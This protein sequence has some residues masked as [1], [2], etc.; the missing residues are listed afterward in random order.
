MIGRGTNILITLAL[1]PCSEAFPRF[2]NF[3][4]KPLY[5]V[6]YDR[7]LSKAT[8]KRQEFNFSRLS[9]L[10]FRQPRPEEKFDYI[11]VGG[12]A[13][14]CPLARTLSEAGWK[15]LLIERGPTRDK[16]HLSWDFYGQGTQF[17]QVF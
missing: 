7:K 15:T 13:S 10:N 14:G 5:R 11:I 4:L 8:F 17:P 2:F 1:Y 6:Q 9:G 16:V 3:G 12:G